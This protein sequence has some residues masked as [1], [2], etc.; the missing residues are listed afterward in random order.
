MI[1]WIDLQ[2]SG[3]G[4]LKQHPQATT[5]YMKIVDG[6]QMSQLCAHGSE[7]KTS[8]ALMFES[9]HGNHLYYVYI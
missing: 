7:L 6:L 1:S 4:S 9:E 8:V 3:D 2:S 5:K